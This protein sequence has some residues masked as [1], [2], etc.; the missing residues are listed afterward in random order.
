VT[1]VHLEQTLS[2]HRGSVQQEYPA[3]SYLDSDWGSP[4]TYVN[5]SRLLYSTA[6]LQLHFEQ[7]SQR[8]TLAV[9]LCSSCHLEPAAHN[10]GHCLV[11]QVAAR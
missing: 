1:S 2:T 3:G 11:Y 9:A 5:N 7:R 8:L 10:A 4:A 6:D